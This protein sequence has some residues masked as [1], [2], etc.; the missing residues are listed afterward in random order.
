MNRSA[1][2]AD[3]TTMMANAVSD[4]LRDAGAVVVGFADLAPLDETTRQGF[5]RA[6]SFAMPLIPAIVAGT[7]AYLQTVGVAPEA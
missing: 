7:H 4:R 3:I 6:V 5:P 2:Q 1:I